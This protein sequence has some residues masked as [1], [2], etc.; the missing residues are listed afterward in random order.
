MWPVALQ[1]LTT[2]MFDLLPLPRC[3]TLFWPFAAQTL[4]FVGVKGHARLIHIVNLTLAYHAI[5][6]LLA[7]FQG[8]HSSRQ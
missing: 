8:G 5:Q 2:V 7:Q 6:T 1:E 4:S 3:R